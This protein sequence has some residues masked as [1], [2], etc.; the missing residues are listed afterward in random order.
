MSHNYNY[1]CKADK[2]DVSEA[3]MIHY[4]SGKHARIE[5]G[6]YIYS[7]ELWYSAFDE[8]RDTIP[9]EWI[10]WDRQLRKNLEKHDGA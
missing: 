3:K 6:K 2:G 9:A 5:K 1:H 7:S 10:Q 8:I 4:C